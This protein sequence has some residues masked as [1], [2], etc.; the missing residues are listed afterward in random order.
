MSQEVIHE[1]DLAGQRCERCR[2]E[3][4]GPA[5]WRAGARFAA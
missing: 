5:R 1:A 2:A 3:I 4:A